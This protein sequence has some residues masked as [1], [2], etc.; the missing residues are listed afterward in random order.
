MHS[1]LR[2]ERSSGSLDRKREEDIR[3]VYSEKDNFEDWYVL[4]GTWKRKNCRERK[5]HRGLQLERTLAIEIKA[6][7]RHCLAFKC[8]ESA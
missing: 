7:R 8:N 3:T 6:L 2:G 1:E 4:R 5:N